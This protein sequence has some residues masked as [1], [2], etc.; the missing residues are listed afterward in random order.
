MSIQAMCVCVST[1]LIRW[2]VSS[3]EVMA[4]GDAWIMCK[5]MAGTLFT[6]NKRAFL[7]VSFRNN[8]VLC[9]EYSRV[10]NFVNTFKQFT[11]YAWCHNFELILWWKMCTRQLSNILLGF[12]III[13]MTTCSYVYRKKITQ[14]K[15]FCQRELPR[16]KVMFLHNLK[17]FTW[18]AWMSYIQVD[19]TVQSFIV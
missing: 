7:V 3:V 2:I 10:D 5:L 15:T 14:N 1:V 8:N 16:T 12:F 6:L 13:M 4:F 17:Q 11:W 9:K 19:N 18:Y